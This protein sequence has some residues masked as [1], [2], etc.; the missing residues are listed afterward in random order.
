M[1]D[2]WLGLVSRLIGLIIVLVELRLVRYAALLIRN[3]I[4]LLMYLWLVWE[5]R[6]PCG[7]GGM[8]RLL[9]GLK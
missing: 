9:L 1:R 6:Y 5:G 8:M 2:I 3:L 4:G 7:R